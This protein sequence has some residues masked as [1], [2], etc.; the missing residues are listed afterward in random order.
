[1]NAHIIVT[2]AGSFDR[3][4][5]LASDGETAKEV[6]AFT[7]QLVDR[8]TG[9]EEPVNIRTHPSVVSELNVETQK[10]EYIGRARFSIYR[11]DI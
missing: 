5:I 3:V 1:M 10:R 7:K 6:L 9:S 2:R 11:K 8:I 4:N